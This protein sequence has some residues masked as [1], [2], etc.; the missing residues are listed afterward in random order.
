MQLFWLIYVF[1]INSIYFG[2]CF[3]PSSGALNCIYSTWYCPPT[4]S[5]TG[6]QYQKL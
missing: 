1:V 6:G 3:C 4:G 5:N 2:R